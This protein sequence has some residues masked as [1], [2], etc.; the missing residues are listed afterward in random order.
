MRW[1]FKNITTGD[2]NEEQDAGRSLAGERSWFEAISG[3]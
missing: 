1:F 3:A 2:W